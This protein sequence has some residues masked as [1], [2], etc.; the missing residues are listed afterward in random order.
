M[1]VFV[2]LISGLADAKAKKKKRGGPPALLKEWA[3]GCPF[4]RDK[5]EA[6]ELSQFGHELERDGRQPEALRCYAKAIRSSPAEAVGWYDL[7]IARQH[8]DPPQ[9]VRFYRQGLALKP[10]DHESY[11]QMGVLLRTNGRQEEAVRH[12]RVA[13][14]LRPTDADS[15]FHLGGSHDMLERHSEA[16]WA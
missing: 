9:A 13:S 15:F 10:A 2:L 12:F 8:V 14:R 7:A 5:A 1:A 3:S 6:E 11:N 4:H 16:L